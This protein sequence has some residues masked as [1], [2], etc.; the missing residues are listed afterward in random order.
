MVWIKKRRIAGKHENYSLSKKLKKDGKI[1]EQFEIMLNSLTL[2][3]IIGLKI[4]LAYRAAN[5]AI[6]GLP[7]WRKMID[8]TKNALLLYAV[9]ATRSNREASR[10]LGIDKHDFRRY[11]NEYGV[12]TYFESGK[13]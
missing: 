12:N 6:F 9:S 8:I 11:V 4:E 10:M 3:E 1:S 7:L 2:E 5:T 13:E